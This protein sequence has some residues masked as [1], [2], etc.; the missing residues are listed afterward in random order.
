MTIF[1]EREM[2]QFSD[3]TLIQ[4][5]KD[6]VVACYFM[7]LFLS[8][9]FLHLAATTVALAIVLVSVSVFHLSSSRLTSSCAGN[10]LFHLNM[11][12]QIL[13]SFY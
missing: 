8:Q 11:L 9:C 12:E 7:W 13:D 3:K 10:C 1:T 2:I 4:T 5:L 6:A